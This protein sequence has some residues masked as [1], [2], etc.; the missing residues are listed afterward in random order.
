MPAGGEGDGEGKGL[1]RVTWEL[2]TGLRREATS[3]GPSTPSCPSHPWPGGAVLTR[4]L[5][6]TGHRLSLHPGGAPDSYLQPGSGRESWPQV[7]GGAPACERPGLPLPGRREELGG[8]WA[9]RAGLSS[10]RSFGKRPG[11]QAPGETVPHRC[12]EGAASVH[13]CR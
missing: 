2:A 10:E 4:C 5:L 9:Q 12:G 7:A 11:R 13:I 3:W 6:P 1:L 8:S